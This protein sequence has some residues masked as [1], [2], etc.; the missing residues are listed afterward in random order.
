MH[1][2]LAPSSKTNVFA[3]TLHRRV[4]PHWILHRLESKSIRTYVYAR[5]TIHTA[6]VISMKHEGSRIKGLEAFEYVP[7]ELIL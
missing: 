4:T 5:E 2:T 3:P 1:L 6:N 7:Y